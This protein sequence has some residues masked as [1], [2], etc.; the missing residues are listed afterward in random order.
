MRQDF[1]QEAALLA[2]RLG[3]PSNLMLD[4]SQ[5]GRV[6]GRGKST[7]HHYRRN[8]PD[9]LPPALPGAYPRWYLPAVLAWMAG[10]TD[11]SID[12]PTLQPDP[13]RPGRPTKAEVVAR[14]SAAGGV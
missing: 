11:Q 7:V 9:Y 8:H 3:L 12:P 14:R 6:L 13:R 5:L 1:F 10:V 4:P 2:D